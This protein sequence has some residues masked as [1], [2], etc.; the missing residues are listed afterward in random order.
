MVAFTG[1]ELISEE[2]GGVV[3]LFI[4]YNF[5]LLTTKISQVPLFSS[6]E[7]GELHHQLRPAPRVIS[8]NN[9]ST[10]WPSP[11]GLPVVYDLPGSK[12]GH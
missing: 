6:I 5:K 11:S 4:G 7:L 2:G 12:L 1:F 3:V 8:L 10:G 9:F